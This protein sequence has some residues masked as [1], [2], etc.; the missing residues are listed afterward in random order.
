[1]STVHSSRVVSLQRIALGLLAWAQFAAPM[2]AVHHLDEGLIPALLFYLVSPLLVLGLFS[3]TSALLV[4]A[5]GVWAWKT[6]PP[7]QAL[8]LADPAAGL[9]AWSLVWLALTPCGGSFSWDRWRARREGQPAPERGDLLGTR[10]LQLHLTVLLLVRALDRSSWHYLSGEAFR[11]AAHA[12][13]LETAPPGWAL[14]GVA[15]LTFAAGWMLPVALWLP[16]TRLAAVAAV[17]G[18]WLIVYPVLPVGVESLVVCVLAGSFLDPEQVHRA[19]DR[20]LG[21]SY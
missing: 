20:L 5:L 18:G 11:Q 15:L 21:R 10:L 12:L 16:A 6:T 14:Q 9:L 1:V 2:R 4:G 8:P 13:H 7:G 19:I 17:C 3:R